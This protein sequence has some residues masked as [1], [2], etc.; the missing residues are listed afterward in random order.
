MSQ[1]ASAVKRAQQNEVQPHQL[2]QEVFK[3]MLSE[4]VD[5]K[6]FPASHL[7]SGG[8]SSWSA[9][10]AQPLRNQGQSAPR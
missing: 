4:D 5:W 6:L 7:P 8:P 2:G 3:T 9:L 1:K 10:G